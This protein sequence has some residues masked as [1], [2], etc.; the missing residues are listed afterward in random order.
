[1]DYK[2]LLLYFL[3]T[4]KKKIYLKAIKSTSKKITTSQK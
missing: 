4:L 2:I 3:F 1:M